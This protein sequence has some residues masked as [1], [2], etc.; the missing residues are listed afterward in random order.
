[1]RAR[2]PRVIAG[3]K[4]IMKGR[5][6]KDLNIKRLP[7]QLQGMLEAALK[8]AA[9]NLKEDINNLVWRIDRNGCIHIKDTR[10]KIQ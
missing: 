4:A 7:A 5:G 8:D 1:M 10:M 3:M 6:P 2:C 9:E